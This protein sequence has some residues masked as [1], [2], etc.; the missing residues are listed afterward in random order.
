MGLAVSVVPPTASASGSAAREADFLDRVAAVGLADRAVVTGAGRHRDV[1][2]GR[3][4]QDG[5]QLGSS[6]W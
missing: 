6:A 4:A 5:V 1:L 3:P 2:R